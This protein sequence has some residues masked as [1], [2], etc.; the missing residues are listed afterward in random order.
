MELRYLFFLLCGSLLGASSF[1]TVVDRDNLIGSSAPGVMG[2]GN[3]GAVL[4]SVV[5]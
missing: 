2:E 4:V 1:A 5:R 3:G